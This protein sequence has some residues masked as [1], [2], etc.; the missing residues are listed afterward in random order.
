M[1]GQSRILTPA[2]LFGYVS[3]VISNEP[4]HIYCSFANDQPTG[5]VFPFPY[6]RNGRQSGQCFVNF[7]P[8]TRDRI[9]ISLV[10]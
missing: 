2:Q 7:A 5:V 6:F 4:L 10:N 1:Q 9:L 8:F 3:A